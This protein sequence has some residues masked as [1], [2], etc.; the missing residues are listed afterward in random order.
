MNA[1]VTRA[2]VSEFGS[3]EGG[4]Q[5]DGDEVYERPDLAG[6]QEFLDWKRQFRNNLDIANELYHDRCPGRTQLPW[7]ASV[8]SGTV[9]FLQCELLVISE[10]T[11]PV[12]EEF[13]EMLQIHKAGYAAL[14][15]I[16]VC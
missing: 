3:A 12:A 15:T 7:P 8:T 13:S 5:G 6:R 16:E 4:G 1:V 9:R 2:V 14:L 11:R 10:C